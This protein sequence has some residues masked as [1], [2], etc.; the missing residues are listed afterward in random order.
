MARPRKRQLFLFVE[1]DVLENKI[2]RYVEP[3]TVCSCSPCN[4]VGAWR[5]RIMLIPDGCLTS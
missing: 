4:V 1:G 2:T 3:S 5:L